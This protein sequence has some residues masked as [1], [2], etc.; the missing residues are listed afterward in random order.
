[1]RFEKFALSFGVL[2]VFHFGVGQTARGYE[3][4]ASYDGG[5]WEDPG[6][7]EQTS[8]HWFDATASADADGS[9][10]SQTHAYADAKD[11]DNGSTYASAEAWQDWDWDWDGPPGTAPGGTL[12]WSE[13]SS[14][15]AY[16]TGGT[17]YPYGS[18]SSS[19]AYAVSAGGGGGP[20]SSG[21]AGG[22]A[23]GSVT[24]G[25]LATGSA[26]ASGSP[27]PYVN[28]PSENPAYGSYRYDID[29]AQYADGDDNISAGTT[30]ICFNGES[31]CS[32]SVDVT[33]GGPN[34]GSAYSYASASASLS[35]SFSSN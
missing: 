9:C 20:V 19:S 34:S 29:W 13:D 32:S 8:T 23:S 10:S 26:S 14:G 6:P 35:A 18:G 12:S 28:D 5:V 25:Q 30:N 24:D 15:N 11:G 3:Y 27:D 7:S 22:S 17:S 1:M 16:V 2:V 33:E 31:V 4:V 21:S